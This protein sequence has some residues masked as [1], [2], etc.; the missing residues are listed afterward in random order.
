MRCAAAAGDGLSRSKIREGCCKTRGTCRHR[1]LSP[2]TRPVGGRPMHLRPPARPGVAASMP[3]Q[4]LRLAAAIA[5][6]GLLAAPGS[7]RLEAAGTY[8]CPAQPC[9]GHNNK[10]LLP[11]DPAH[12][13]LPAVQRVLAWQF[14]QGGGDRGDSAGACSVAD[15]PGGTMRAPCPACG[16]MAP[17]SAGIRTATRAHQQRYRAAPGT[18]DY[19]DIGHRNRQPGRHF[20]FSY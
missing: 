13:P 17:A 18:S 16:H 9:P 14:V 20:A 12:F 8:G 6:A 10:T 3:A 15:C 19:S 2:P 1:S 7:V 11:S 5:M 4:L